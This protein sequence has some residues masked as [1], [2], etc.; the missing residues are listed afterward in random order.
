METSRFR[1]LCY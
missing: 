1:F